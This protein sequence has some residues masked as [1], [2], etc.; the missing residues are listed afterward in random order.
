ML[1]ELENAPF[2][3][4]PA[5][6]GTKLKEREKA[7]QVAQIN[8]NTCSKP[9]GPELPPKLDANKPSDTVNET[10]TNTNGL[11]VNVVPKETLNGVKNEEKTPENVSSTSSGS[12]SGSSTNTSTPMK[13][14]PY[15][16][17]SSSSD[18]SP[19]ESNSR[20]STKAALGE[21]KVTSTGDADKVTVNELLKMS[22]GGYAAP[23]SAWNGT[24]AGLDKEVA[25]E[26]REDRKRSLAEAPENGRVKHAKPDGGFKSNPGYNP[27]QVSN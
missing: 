13:L 14:V 12:A 21:W 5:A 23:V 6:N 7:P 15:D 22:H 9:Y 3:Q 24:R 20:V 8:G 27:I 18:E 16:D 26:K 4:K 17:E 1:Y 11:S 25:A 2:A 19:E 10:L